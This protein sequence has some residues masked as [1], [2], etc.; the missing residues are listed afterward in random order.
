MRRQGITDQH[1]LQ[2]RL[3]EIFEAVDHQDSAL[4]RVYQMLFPDWHRIIRI[5]GYPV[6]GQELWCY[7]CNLFIHFDQEHHPGIFKGGLWLNNGFSS[8]SGLD[9]WE[10][11]FAG[12]NVVY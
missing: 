12:C 4:T 10:I 1:K 2:Q 11:S 8:S 3:Q 9:P 5:E 7:I 6:V